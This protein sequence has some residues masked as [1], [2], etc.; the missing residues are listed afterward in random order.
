MNNILFGFIT[1]ILAGLSTLL[2]FII[3]NLKIK[4]ENI[5]N[6]ICFCLAF[7]LSIM[8]SISIFDLIPT[9]FSNLF[10]SLGLIKSMLIFLLG[11]FCSYIILKLVNNIFISTNEVGELYKLGLLN[12]IVLIIHNL[13]EGIATFLSSYHSKKLGI[14]ISFAIMLHNIPE[15]IGISVP[16]YYA[17]K[18]KKKAFIATLLSSLAEPC[19]AI[20]SF[21]FLKQFINEKMINIILILVACLMITLSIEEIYPKAIKYNKGKYLILGLL[22]GVVL[23]IINL[24]LFN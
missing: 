24:L 6:F 11:I 22:L 19:G 1:S 12:M 17:T 21:F 3:V 18:S 5:N 20:F 13:P 23:V 9:C 16:I 4:E 10:S 2:G 15:G 7:S 14:K 8:I